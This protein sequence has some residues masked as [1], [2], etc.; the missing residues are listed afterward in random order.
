MIHTWFW[1]EIQ[2]GKRMLGRP[3]RRWEDII[4]WIL[5][6]LDG[7]GMFWINVVQEWDQ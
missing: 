1:W 2:K 5:E 7:G 4:N 6:K 3:R